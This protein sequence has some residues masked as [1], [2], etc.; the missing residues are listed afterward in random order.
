[1]W[2][3]ILEKAYAS[4]KGSYDKIGAGGS[5]GDAL[6]AILGAR[7]TYSSVEDYNADRVYDSLKK[8]QENGWPVA[9]ATYGKDGPEAER[10][11]GQKVYPW[12]AYT[13]MGVQEEDG[14]KYVQLRNPWG[15]TEPGYDGKDDGMFRLELKDFV[16]YYSG[17]TIAQG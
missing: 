15:S 3:P 2:Y 5:T 6:T 7:T 4:Y 14:K 17:V 8:A 9:A 1:M 13:V 16:H 12:H 10:Y 11:A